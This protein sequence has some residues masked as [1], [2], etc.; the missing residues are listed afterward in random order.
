MDDD[1]AI[2]DLVTTFLD[3]VDDIRT[4]GETDPAVAVER[5]RED[6]V[7]CVVSDYQMPGMDGLELLSAVREIDP[8]MPFILFTG[9]GS[10]SVASEAVS[11]GVTDYIRKST[12]TD[13]YHLLAN[14]VRN[15][16]EGRRART[17]YREVFDAASDAILV[18]DPES[19]TIVDANRATER[20]WGYDASALESRPI[21]DLLVDVTRVRDTVPTAGD[22]AETVD[23]RCVRADGDRFWAEASLESGTFEGQD[24]RL[25]VFRDVTQRR[26][27]ERAIDRLVTGQQELLAAESE[28]ALGAAAANVAVD[29]LSLEAATVYARDGAALATLASA[30]MPTPADRE[31]RARRTLGGNEPVLETTD[32]W[33]ELHVPV[34]DRGVVVGVAART[35]SFAA[36]EYSLALAL[37][38]SLD[39]ALERIERERQLR[40]RGERLA[41]RR[42]ELRTTDRINAVIRNVHWSLVRA[43]SLEEIERLVCERLAASDPYSSVWMGRYDV[44]AGAIE[45]SAAAGLAGGLGEP[46]ALADAPTALSAAITNLSTEIVQDVSLEPDADRTILRGSDHRSIA[47]VPVVNRSSLYGIVAIAADEPDVF[48]DG[49]REVLGELGELIGAAITA[50]RRERAL[51]ADDVVELEFEVTSGDSLVGDLSA[52]VDDRVDVESILE[53]GDDALSMFVTVPGIDADR[54]DGIGA[55]HANVRSVEAVDE[56]RGR[57]E[58]VVDRAPLIDDLTDLGA[59]MGRMWGESGRVR[60]AIEFPGDVDVRRCVALMDS[61]YESTSLVARRELVGDAGTDRFGAPIPAELTDRQREVLRVAYETGF[62]EWPRAQTGEEVAERLDISQSTFTEHLRSGERKVFEALFGDST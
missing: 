29:V 30:G 26:N 41:Q 12:S 2:V 54:I 57:Y 6:P 36:Y 50:T 56:R 9:R 22:R 48:G 10:E 8:E 11:A 35:R 4:D 60:F 28:A 14:R 23:V 59:S 58:I 52:A 53:T 3:D 32:N 24:L 34:G 38:N 15:A 49:E 25:A 45:P 62:F 27:R 44:D 55:E 13:Q 61:A 20:L 19:E 16:V 17:N 1:P 21:E 40:D 7:E 18:V 31:S 5:V 33:R 47:Y 37:G 51:F 39:T 46:V 42:D 43:S